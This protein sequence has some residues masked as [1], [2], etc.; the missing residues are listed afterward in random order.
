MQSSKRS[1]AKDPAASHLVR[2]WKST[3]FLWLIPPHY[4]GCH[5]QFSQKRVG[6]NQGSVILAV[7]STSI[8]IPVVRVCGKW[9]SVFCADNR[10][11]LEESVY[12]GNN[13]QMKHKILSADKNIIHVAHIPVGLSSLWFN[14]A[15]PSN[16]TPME[17]R[18]SSWIYTNFC[19]DIFMDSST[20]VPLSKRS[21]TKYTVKHLLGPLTR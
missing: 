14:T 8:K 13:F 10:M 1:P 19:D 3:T 5:L 6:L 16:S 2:T 15:N 11:H 18:P 20:S 7:D 21:V 12:D 17:V 9:N 4:Y